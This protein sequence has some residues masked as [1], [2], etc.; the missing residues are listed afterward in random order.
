MIEEIVRSSL[1][2]EAMIAGLSSEPMPWQH[3]WRVSRN[4]TRRSASWRP[5]PWARPALPGS[6]AVDFTVAPLRRGGAP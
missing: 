6:R 5:G 1:E 2:D 4:A 3:G